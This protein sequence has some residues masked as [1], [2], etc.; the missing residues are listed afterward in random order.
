MSILSS[1]QVKELATLVIKENLKE[2]QSA[3]KN[4]KKF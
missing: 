3:Y 4:I 1:F 2:L